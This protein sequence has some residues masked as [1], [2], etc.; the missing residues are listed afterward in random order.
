MSSKAHRS[1]GKPR[2]ESGCRYVA[3]R[4]STKLLIIDVLFSNGC[5]YRYRGRCSGETG[6]RLSGIGAAIDKGI[7]TMASMGDLNGQR[8]PRKEAVEEEAACTCRD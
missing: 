4:H 1:R 3:G 5:H 2:Y 8:S 6:C 7:T